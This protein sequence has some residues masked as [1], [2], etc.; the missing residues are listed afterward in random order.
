MVIAVASSCPHA[1]NDDPFVG[2]P[3][4]EPI[5]EP[6]SVSWSCDLL[7]SDGAH[8]IDRLCPPNRNLAV[9]S[10]CEYPLAAAGYFPD[11]VQAPW[12]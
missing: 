11:C 9:M 5:G 10:P 4:L 3:R 12:Q 2:E 7:S 6:V 8:M 1:L